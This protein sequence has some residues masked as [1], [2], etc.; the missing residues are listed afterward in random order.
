MAR[1]ARRAAFYGGARKDA[2]VAACTEAAVSAAVKVNEEDAAAECVGLEGDDKK[3]FRG[4]AAL[5]SY[6]GQDRPDLQ[7]ATNQICRCM[8][9]PI[10]AGRR[11]VKRAVRYLVGAEKGYLAL[12][13]V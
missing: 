6:L 12:R 5:L 8:A 11:K 1:V 4:E 13:G 3:E 9:R 2:E 10:E 7:F